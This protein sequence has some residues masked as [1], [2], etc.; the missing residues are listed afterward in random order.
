MLPTIERLFG[1]QQVRGRL[2]RLSSQDGTDMLWSHKLRGFR[3]RS[4]TSVEQD[5]GADVASKRFLEK[6][7]HVSKETEYQQIDVIDVLDPR[8]A[9]ITSYE[10]SIA[11]GNSYESLHPKLFE[12]NRMVFLGGRIQSSL[13]GESD[14][15]EGRGASLLYA[16]K[17]L[18]LKHFLHYCSSG[19]PR[20]D[21]SSNS[22]ASS[23][24]WRRRR[25]NFT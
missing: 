18:S 4:W 15:H 23:H 6:W 24:H 13:K 21:H 16:P 25:R 22:K 10:R 2:D 17:Y 1:I 9:S 3:E 12:P 8:Y 14:Y 5:F 7:H 11:N 20:H 19:T